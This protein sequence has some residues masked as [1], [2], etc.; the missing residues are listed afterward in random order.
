M[1]IPSGQTILLDVS[2][3]YLKALVIEG[4]LIFEDKN[5]ELHTEYI[6]I[7]NGRLQIGT[8]EKPIQSKITVTLYG[9]KM[10]RF[11]PHYGN[12]VIA[13]REGILDIHG[14]PVS[15]TWSRLD[16][17]ANVGTTQITLLDKVN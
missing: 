9:S 10:S 16:S 1:H 7:R 11:L 4:A 3:P 12:K 8:W 6:M 13:L 17:T 2:P 14:T 15:H 5:L